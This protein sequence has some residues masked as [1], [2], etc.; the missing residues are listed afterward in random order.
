M[1]I[2]FANRNLIMFCFLFL[3]TFVSLLNDVIYVFVC[4]YE[5]TYLS[6]IML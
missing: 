6:A 3:H 2:H 1:R 4:M 5:C